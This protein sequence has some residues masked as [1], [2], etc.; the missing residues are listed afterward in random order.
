M[1][2]RRLPGVWISVYTNLQQI[3]RQRSTHCL[4]PFPPLRSPP[5]PSFLGRCG[6]SSS[7]HVSLTSP[8]ETCFLPF[9]A[10]LRVI[11]VSASNIPKTKFGKP[12]PIVSVIFKGK[13]KFSSFSQALFWNAS[14][15]ESHS[16]KVYLGD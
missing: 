8:A 2:L 6:R 13:E 11:V 10:M 7:A 9:R 14:F 5:K 12:D 1:A 16:F 3:I 4:F 15:L